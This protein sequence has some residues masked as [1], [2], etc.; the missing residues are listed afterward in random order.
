MNTFDRLDYVYKLLII[1]A[2]SVTAIILCADI[3]IP[4]AFA[5]LF[6][7]VMMPLVYHRFWFPWVAARP[8]DH[9]PGK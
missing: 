9:Q 8:S 2:L 1:I 7:I 4:F 3:V 6:A 5:A